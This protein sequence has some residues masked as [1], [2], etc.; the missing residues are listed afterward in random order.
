MTLNLN[1]D[2]LYTFIVYSLI[3]H[4]FLVF[5]LSI[6][7]NIKKNSAEHTIDVTLVASKTKDK[8]KI[9]DYLAQASNMGGGDSNS[10]NIPTNTTKALFPDAELKEVVLPEEITPEDDRLQ[11]VNKKN[12][13]VTTTAETALKS[14]NDPSINDS[15]LEKLPEFKPEKATQEFLD[16]KIQLTSLVSK[17][18]E[19]ADLLAK[20]PK[21]RFVSASSQEYRD[22]EYLVKWREKIEYFGNKY[23]P[24]QARSR[25]LAGEVILLVSLRA[26][27]QIEKVQVEKSSGVKILDEAAIQTVHIAA[28]FD[29]FPVEM[30][31]DTD[32]LEIV[33]TWRFNNEFGL[34]TG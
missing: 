28:P 20:R 21:R 14:T 23:Y 32:V 19:R 8:P 29:P 30:S 18:G 26:N 5:G 17:I 4:T 2:S 12:N 7:W 25:N 9:P 3:I 15:K 16:K 27:G 13:A 31:K 1:R 34:R 11:L 10:K 33:R 24:E 22:A 6:Q